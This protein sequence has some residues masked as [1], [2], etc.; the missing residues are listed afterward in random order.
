V[1]DKPGLFAR[2][3]GRFQAHPV[4]LLFLVTFD[5]TALLNPVKIG[6]L[7]WGVSKLTAFGFLG[8]W[9]DGRFF[10]LGQPED[11]TGQAQGAAWKRKGLIIAAAIIAGALVP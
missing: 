2:L 11:H 8:A 10:P 7:L 4:L 6:L 5:V 3:L 1:S 9:I